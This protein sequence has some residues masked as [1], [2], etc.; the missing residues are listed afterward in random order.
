MSEQPSAARIAGGVFL[1]LAAFFIGLPLVLYFLVV[2]FSSYSNASNTYRAE[3]VNHQQEVSE[4]DREAWRQ[5]KAQ[6]A[7]ELSA[8]AALAQMD[9]AHAQVESNR[10]AVV[11]ARLDA[12]TARKQRAEAAKRTLLQYRT[13]HAR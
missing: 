12:E 9:A 1:G 10:Q 8:R 11:Q 5:V 4:A 6:R 7:K 2:G 13:T 3:E